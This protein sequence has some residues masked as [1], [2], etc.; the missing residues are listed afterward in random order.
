MNLFFILLSIS[1]VLFF[2]FTL[3]FGN[4]FSLYLVYLFV[5]LF[6]T[7][8]VSAVV[9]PFCE[10]T[11]IVSSQEDIY[12]LQDNISSSSFGNFIVYH[13]SEDNK[14]FY[15]IFDEETNGL[16]YSS[17]SAKDVILKFDDNPRLVKYKTI[18]KNKNFRNW[19][20]DLNVKT[21]TVLYVPENS[22]VNSI[23]IDLK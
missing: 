16:K 7:L 14:Y 17:I 10:T 19:F 21:Y 23:N 8:G 12:S 11:D 20:F 3:L 13:S 9:V 15:Y 6:I 1:F 22:V 18:T 2:V 4:Q 5:P